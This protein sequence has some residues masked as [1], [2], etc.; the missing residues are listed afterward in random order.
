MKSKNTVPFLPRANRMVDVRNAK[1][2]DSHLC[3]TMRFFATAYRPKVILRIDIAI[4][5]TVLAI[6]RCSLIR[7]RIWCVVASD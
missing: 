1:K 6:L 2:N 7:A 5:S 3:D 4:V